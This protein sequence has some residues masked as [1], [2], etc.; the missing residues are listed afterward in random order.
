MLYNGNKTHPKILFSNYIQKTYNFLVGGDVFGK[1]EI[2]TQF[3][4]LCLFI[5]YKLTLKA[6]NTIFVVTAS[7]FVVNELI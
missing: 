1:G 2:V 7:H 5:S 4:W 6:Q 3:H